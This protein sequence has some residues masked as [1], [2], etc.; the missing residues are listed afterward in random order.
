ML[1]TISITVS[2]KVQG[3]YFRQSAKEKAQELG[4]TGEIKNQ[5]NGNVFV[6]ASGTKEQL[7]NFVLWCKLGPSRAVVNSVI[8]ADEV[9][10]QFEKF[11]IVR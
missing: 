5:P 1:Q 9:F 4:I 6:I 10:R 2:G 7:D 3:V 11:R 8:T